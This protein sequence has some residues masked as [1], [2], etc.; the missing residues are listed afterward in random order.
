MLTANDRTDHRDRLALTWVVAEFVENSGSDDRFA[1]ASVE[2]EPKQST[3]R[4]ERPSKLSLDDVRSLF[5]L[6]YRWQAS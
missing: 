3:V 2:R 1:R 5:G 6:K 4:V